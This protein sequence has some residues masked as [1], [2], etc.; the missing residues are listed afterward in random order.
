MSIMLTGYQWGDD[1]SYIGTYLFPNNEDQEYVHLPP[2]TTL[3]PPPYP[4]PGYEAAI[5]LITGLWITRPENLSW[6][7]STEVLA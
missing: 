3:I 6:V 1:N 7:T 2:R 5:D 4:D